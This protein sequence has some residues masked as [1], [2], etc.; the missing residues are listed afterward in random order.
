MSSRVK[1]I[2]IRVKN[3]Y[4]K[5]VNNQRNFLSSLYNEYNFSSLNDWKTKTWKDIR[6]NGGGSLLNIYNNDFPK[7]LST[8]YPEHP[9]EFSIKKT[10]RK[11]SFWKNIDNQRDFMNSLS[12][13]LDLKSLDDWKNRNWRDVLENGGGSLLCIYNKNLHLLLEKVYPIHQWNFKKDR[14]KKGYWTEKENH[15]LFFHQLF[16]K[17]QLTQLDDF[18]RISVQRYID[19]GGK[20]LLLYYNFDT[21]R[22]L[23]LLFPNFPWD[24]TKFDISKSKLLSLQ[25]KYQIEKK[26]DWYRIRAKDVRNLQTL[27]YQVHSQESWTISEFTKRSKKSKQRWLFICLCNIY[28][29]YLIIENYCHPLLLSTSSLLSYELDLFIP[30]LNEGFEY[31]GE[32]HYDDIPS[33][34]APSHC[35]QTRDFARENLCIKINI[36]LISIP[37]WWNLSINSLASFFPLFITK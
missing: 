24:F 10:K 5:N 29:Q 9:W 1:P 15:F 23:T 19:N 21:K 28:P 12:D 36:S 14:K 33:S 18:K 20:S 4:W 25:L 8:L 31:N 7:L 34:F 35:Y 2:R 22:M 3:G 27:L 6:L 32:Q 30:E 37:Y 26:E 17:L 16:D 13:K 11:R